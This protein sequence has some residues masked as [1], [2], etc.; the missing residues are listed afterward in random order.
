M[1]FAYV[2]ILF[3]G[4]FVGFLLSLTVKVSSKPTVRGMLQVIGAALGGT[5]ILFMEGA[6]PSKWAYPV[7]LVLGLI[8]ARRVV[9]PKRPGRGSAAAKSTG[10]RDTLVPT[11]I[12]LVVVLAFA[13]FQD[14]TS[15][16]DGGHAVTRSEL[17]CN[18]A[19]IYL[20]RF[21]KSRSN[22]E[23]PPGFRLPASG[24]QKSPIPDKGDYIIT[25]KELSL[26][27]SGYGAAVPAQRCNRILDPPWG[28]RPE[29]A[30]EYQ[31]GRL[32]RDSKVLVNSVT[33]M[34]TP[35]ADPFYVWALVGAAKD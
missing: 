33:L 21:S 3:L 6:G 12:S 20:G 8:W 2:G 29:T 24:G 5:P 16:D 11:V 14:R 30:A 31:A 18:L 35:D 32:P 1:N 26:L 19:W 15:T 27:V 25:T 13:F 22:Y 17:P 7:G 4:G 28:Y 9:A 23:L 10:W 34:P